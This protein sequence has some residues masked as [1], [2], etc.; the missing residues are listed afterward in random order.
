MGKTAL[1]LSEKEWQAYRPA[2]SI[3]EEPDPDRLNLAWSLART[4]ADLL[5]ERFGA[6]RV[7]VFGS[8][9]HDEWFTRWSDIDLAAWG[10]SP[11]AFF[12]AVA[13]VTGLSTE[14]KLDLVDPQDCRP[15]LRR[16]IEREG[17]AV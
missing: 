11:E 10:I 2:S 16:A 7:V 3:V 12:R 9:A 13:A 14:F 17:V 6:T 4:A 1:E 5:R 15:A 8:L